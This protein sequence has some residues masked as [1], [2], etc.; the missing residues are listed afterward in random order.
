MTAVPFIQPIPPWPA[1]PPLE[2]VDRAEFADLACKVEE[3]RAGA[4][5]LRWAFA[6]WI[7]VGAKPRQ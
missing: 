3:V 5:W 6:E 4:A 2:G 7:A 1:R